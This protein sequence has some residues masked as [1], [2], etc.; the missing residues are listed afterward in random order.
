MALASSSSSPGM[1]H[2]IRI[3]K[4]PAAFVGTGDLF[5]ALC[6]AWLQRLSGDLPS[7]LERTIA[8]MQAVLRRTLDHANAAAARDGREKPLP[9]QMELKLIHSKADIEGPKVEVRAEEVAAE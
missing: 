6:T 7:T 2:R 3:P 8:T 1:A 4:L 9:F 5:T